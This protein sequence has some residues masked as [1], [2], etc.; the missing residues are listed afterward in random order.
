MCFLLFQ[1]YYW[2]QNTKSVW[3]FFWFLHF[4]LPFPALVHLIKY[5]KTR[6]GIYNTR[7]GLSWPKYP[8]FLYGV[9]LTCNPSLSLR[10]M[11]SKGERHGFI[12]LPPNESM[13]PRTI[14]SEVEEDFLYGPNRL[15]YV[16][17]VAHRSPGMLSSGC[18]TSATAK[19]SRDCAH[20]RWIRRWFRNGWRFEFLLYRHR[21]FR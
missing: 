15:Q 19:L 6:S 11:V 16:G 10:E 20:M 2:N 5:P 21:V 7:A 8:R 17:E 4:R 14:F 1:D 3:N 18:R 9:T 13:S 12:F